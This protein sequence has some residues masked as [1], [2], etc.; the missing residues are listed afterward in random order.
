MTPA[1]PPI[2]L[3]LVD[4]VRCASALDEIERAAPRLA[5]DDRERAGALGDGS[6]RR[7]RIAAYMA[8]RVLLERAVGAGMR[9]RPLVRDRGG[10]P[11]L[12]DGG[13]WFSLSHTEGGSP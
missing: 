13:A 1:Q 5:D 3:W 10:A 4:L 8:V 11:R 12:A 6:V 2:E 9:R 7:E